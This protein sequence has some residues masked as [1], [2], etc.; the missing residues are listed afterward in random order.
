MFNEP[1]DLPLGFMMQL[2]QDVGAMNY[3]ASLS[4]AEQE[5]LINYMKSATT[6]D[7]A[8]RRIEQT[9]NRLQ[10]HDHYF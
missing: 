8:K 6:G 1:E 10:N 4:E 3:F 9:L 7:E 2:G 5:S